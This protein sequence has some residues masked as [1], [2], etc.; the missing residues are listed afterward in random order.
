M[1]I[2]TLKN[3]TGKRREVK[4]HKLLTEPFKF[5]HISSQSSGNVNENQKERFEDKV[6]QDYFTEKSSTWDSVNQREYPRPTAKSAKLWRKLASQDCKS[7]KQVSS[8]LYLKKQLWS[9]YN[10][11]RWSAG[12]NSITI[13]KPSESVIVDSWRLSR[14]W[15]PWFQI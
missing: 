8:R 11:C 14:H 1:W 2:F 9:Y 5:E 3:K 6:F 13:K 4:N 10:T 7:M 12:K 15:K